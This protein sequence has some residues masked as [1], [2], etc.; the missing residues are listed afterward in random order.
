QF[1]VV[2]L[3]QNLLA[4]SLSP[5]VHGCRRQG[6]LPRYAGDW[7]TCLPDYSTRCFQALC[8]LFFACPILAFSF[9]NPSLMP[10]DFLLTFYN[11]ITLLPFLSCLP[12]AGA[13]A[14]IY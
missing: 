10:L 12:D 13:Y 11:Q 7:P 1:P 4:Q 6:K 9:V 8:M 3:L 14:P 2:P 5:G